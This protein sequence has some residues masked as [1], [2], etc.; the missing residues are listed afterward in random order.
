MAS[1]LKHLSRPNLPEI[2]STTL[3][4]LATVLAG[5]AVTIIATLLT[6]PDVSKI[7]PLPN[8][9]WGLV[10]LAISAPFLLTSAFF[11]VRAQAYSYLNLT[12]DVQKFLKLDDPTFNFHDYLERIYKK[13]LL[14]Y[15]AADFAFFLGLLTFVGGTGFLLWNYIGLVGVLI[16]LTIIILAIGSG[17]WLQLKENKI[18]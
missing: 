14:W 18:S 16:F 1:S 8:P 9:F 6:Q 15:G 11:G 4:L 13:W 5:F 7:W 17:I 2:T 10:L 3:P 12:L